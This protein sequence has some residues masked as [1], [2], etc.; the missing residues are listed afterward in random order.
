MTPEAAP[1]AAPETFDWGPDRGREWARPGEAP[2]LGGP[3][4]G[5]ARVEA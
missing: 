2:R 3:R 4:A 5:A 1:E